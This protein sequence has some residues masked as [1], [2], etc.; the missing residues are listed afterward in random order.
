MTAARYRHCRKP[1]L[2]LLMWIT[3]L[4]VFPPLFDDAEIELAAPGAAVSDK[5]S[6]AVGMTYELKLRTEFGPGQAAAVE[7]VIGRY[8]GRYC[9][10][11][12]PAAPEALRAALGVPIVF[13]VRITDQATQAV[14]VDE[15]FES[16]CSFSGTGSQRTRLVARLALPPGDYAITVTA[17]Q[18]E[19]RLAGTRNVLLLAPP[20]GK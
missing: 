4:C 3:S 19:P 15:T 14:R 20:H 11:G 8:D 6:V 7:A 10:P 5:F 13:Q 9:E 17:P 12:R 1:V 2:G 16:L 18:G